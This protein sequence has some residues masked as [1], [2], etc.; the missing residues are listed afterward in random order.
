MNENER[1]DFI[2]NEIEAIY[3]EIDNSVNHLVLIRRFLQKA[4]AVSKGEE[5][6]YD[7]LAKTVKRI[8]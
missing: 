1:L 2:Y 3:E 6:N 8:K 5:P 7:N 4:V